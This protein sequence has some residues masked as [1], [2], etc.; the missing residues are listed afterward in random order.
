MSGWGETKCLRSEREISDMNCQRSLRLVKKASFTHLKRAFYK[1]V[2][3]LN[4][5]SELIRV[6]FYSVT[7]SEAWAGRLVLYR[8]AGGLAGKLNSLECNG[9]NSI[10]V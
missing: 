5:F 4:P 6:S 3:D 9:V 1:L 7:A 10:V 2:N 8:H